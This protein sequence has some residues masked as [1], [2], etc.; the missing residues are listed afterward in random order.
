MSATCTVALTAPPYSL[1]TYTLP[2]GFEPEE[3]PRGLRLLVPVA[4]TLR[5]GVVWETGAPPPAGVTLRPALWPLERAPLGDAAYLELVENLAS[6][7]L[8]TPGRILGLLLPK[9]LRTSRMVF[10]V[11]ESGLPRRLTSLALSRLGPEAR[12]ALV[13]PWRRGGMRCRLAEDANDPL[14]TLSADPPWPVRP[15]AARQIALLDLLCDLGPMPLSDVKKRLGQGVLPL[16]RRLTSLGL[17]RLDAGQ[18]AGPKAACVVREATPSQDLASAPPLTAEQAAALDALAPVLS[19]PDGAARLVFGVTGSGKT[20]LYM[21]LAA[22]TLALGRRVLL[23]APEVALAVKLHRAATL[24]LPGHD[25]LLY[26]GYQP[27]AVREAAFR[28]AAGNDAPR[29]VAGTRSAL[30]LPLR[31][32]GLIVLDEEHDGAFKQEDRLPYQAK[33]V[34]FFRARQ[35]GALLVLGSATPD[36]KTFHAAREGHV[37]MVR[38]SQRVGGGGMPAIE[39]VDMR[40]ASKLT[41]VAG[42]RETGDRTG[43]LTDRAA[44]ELARTVAAGDQ[45]M[46]LI[47]RRGYAPLL[48]CLDCETPVR[49]PA[50]ELSFTYHKDRERLVCHYCGASRPHPSPCPGC[51]GASFLPMGVGSELLEEQLSGVL[52]AGTAVARLD[53]DVARRP[54]RAEAILEDF[55]SGRAQVLVG[56]QM[57]S[58][59]HH[60]PDVTLVVAADADL[61]RSL[62]DYRASERTF[63]LLTQVAGRAGRGSRPGRVLIQTR[64]PG[65]PFFTHVLAGDFE[66]FFELELSRRRRLCYPPFT[67]LGLARLSFPREFEEGFG[68]VAAAGEAMRRAAAPLGVRVLGPAPAPLAL[69]AGRR[70]FHCLLK[71]PDWPAVRQVFAAARQALAGVAQVRLVLDLDP[72]DML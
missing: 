69:V 42:S 6:R 5:V 11:D 26:H 66:G 59:G 70:R 22:R 72:V 33:E 19:N 2:P 41:S 58:K 47:N 60:F 21:E 9:G 34:A 43:I 49:C 44:E 35:A 71:A 32:I 51:G 62:P 50:C 61:G 14:C 53:R 15:G 1:L 45:A 24:A 8:A 46:I 30:L 3:F 39:L 4:G 10:E 17:V 54:E 31:D 57:L 36:V 64:T 52:P 25:S 38:L 37:P 55:A 12:L 29:L 65:D 13:D 48:F 40:G 63:Q 56:T 20:R 18:S 23:L 7:H 27:P 67:R 16:L 28:R 68:C